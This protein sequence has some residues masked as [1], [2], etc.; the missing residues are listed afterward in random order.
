MKQLHKGAGTEGYTPF[1]CVDLKKYDCQSA[2]PGGIATS[3]SLSSVARFL[4]PAA[5]EYIRVAESDTGARATSRKRLDST[6]WLVAWDRPI[7]RRTGDT[8]HAV[9]QSV[10]DRYAIAAAVTKQLTWSEAMRHKGVV[11]EVRLQS[12]ISTIA[13]TVLASAAGDLAVGQRRLHSHDWR[14]L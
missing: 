6:N 3:V 2:L 9:P 11:M 5:P 1:V 8:W 10:H 7:S 4:P 14:H 12:V 13:A